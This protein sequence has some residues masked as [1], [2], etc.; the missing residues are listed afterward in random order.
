M[1]VSCLRVPCGQTC[2]S[3]CHVARRVTACH[4]AR[5]VTEESGDSVTVL[6][7]ALW[8]HSHG[9]VRWERDTGRVGPLPVYGL[10]VSLAFNML[11]PLLT[12]PS[13]KR[14]KQKLL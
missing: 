14:Y 4:V 8:T 12:L 10:Q 1:G 13:R 5:R 2:D 3:V 9:K 7:K 6:L 11:S